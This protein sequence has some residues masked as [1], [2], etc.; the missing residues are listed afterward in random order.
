MR[1]LQVFLQWKSQVV[2]RSYVKVLKV[3][4]DF[5]LF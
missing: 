2:A 1:V 3:G 5:K 4:M